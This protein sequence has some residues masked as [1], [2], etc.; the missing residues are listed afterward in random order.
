MQASGGFYKQRM[1]TGRKTTVFI[2]PT[3]EFMDIKDQVMANAEIFS[4]I[5]VAYVDTSKRLV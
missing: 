1:R 2:A 4:P 3:A 5:S